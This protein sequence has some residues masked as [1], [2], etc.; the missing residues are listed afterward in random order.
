MPTQSEHHAYYIVT[1]DHMGQCQAYYRPH[2][3]YLV[4]AHF[5]L[6]CMGIFLQTLYSVAHVNYGW[7]V[8]HLT[9]YDGRDCGNVFSETQGCTLSITVHGQFL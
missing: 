3:A 2:M 6:L 7:K 1:Y 8:P 9:M 4:I 5:P